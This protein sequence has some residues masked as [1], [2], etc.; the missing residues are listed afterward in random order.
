[1]VKKVVQQG[2]SDFEARSVLSSTWARQNGENAAGA[3]FQ[4]SHKRYLMAGTYP[5]MQQYATC[6]GRWPNTRV[7]PQRGIGVNPRHI[8]MPGKCKRCMPPGTQT[9]RNS[10]NFLTKQSF[11][12]FSI[13]ALW[14]TIR[15]PNK[16]ARLIIPSWRQTI[17]NFWSYVSNRRRCNN[18]T[19]IRLLEW[20]LL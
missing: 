20:E 17:E 15:W 10:K 7:I 3:F 2:R 18:R 9:Q 14:D 6:F 4:H 11:F 13:K 8:W 12:R 19:P 16:N 1:M 5:P